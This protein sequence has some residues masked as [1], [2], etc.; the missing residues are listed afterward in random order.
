MVE[1]NELG[2]VS[3]AERGATL[4][5]KHP[6]TGE[7]LDLTM[8]VLGFDA[9]PVVQAARAFDR[10]EAKVGG[11]RKPDPIGRRQVALATVAVVGWDGLSMSG[12]VVKFS[13]EKAAEIMADP[14]FV[15]IVSQVCDFGAR[16]RNFF[17]VK[18]GD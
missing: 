5:L 7:E 1:L 14:N 3:A 6:A 12:K 18:S 13:P 8:Q 17:P 4:T 10:E 16:R 2:V 15:W 11:E 9:E